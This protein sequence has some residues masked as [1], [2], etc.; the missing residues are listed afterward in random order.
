MMRF[1]LSVSICLLFYV[2]HAQDT[3]YLDAGLK[4]TGQKNASYIKIISQ[5]ENGMRVK[6]LTGRFTIVSD[7]Y[8][9]DSLFK[10]LSGRAI[11]YHDNG[12]VRSSGIHRNNQR[13]STWNFYFESGQAAATVVF[14]KGNIDKKKYFDLDGRDAPDR[15][16]QPAFKGGNKE[17]GNYLSSNFKI[18]PGK[19]KIHG[20][21]IVGFTITTQGR[22]KDVNIFQ[23]VDKDLDKEAMRV[24]STMPDW[25]PAIQFNTPV[26]VKY[27]VPIAF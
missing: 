15:D 23:S 19:D 18:P 5:A 26:S 3:L 1:I 9:T 10:T 22:I 20:K 11:Y 17:F 4:P 14:N 12:Q 13:D 7:E 16:H 21:I 27:S 25:E 8:Y 24:I 6:T 2:V